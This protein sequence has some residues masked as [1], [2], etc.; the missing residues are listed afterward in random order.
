[1]RKTHISSEAL[2]SKP[3]G[4]AASAQKVLRT[5]DPISSAAKATA[6][7][8][9]S[10]ANVGTPQ[11]PVC[12]AICAPRPRASRTAASGRH[13][14]DR[15]FLVALPPTGLARAI[16]AIRLAR[17]TRVT[18]ATGAIGTPR[19]AWT[20][21]ERNILLH[22]GGSMPRVPCRRT[23]PSVRLI[24]SVDHDVGEAERKGLSYRVDYL[25]D[26]RLTVPVA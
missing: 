7:P 10:R 2:C 19:D 1:M 17:S 9:I 5:G 13:A 14:I 4:C 12:C 8:A 22:V 21:L 20:L 24:G 11:V 18:R 15:S 23:H 6:I 3:V 26:V 16:G 25:L